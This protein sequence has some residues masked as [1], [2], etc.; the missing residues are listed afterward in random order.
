[1]APGGEQLVGRDAELGQMEAWLS[2]VAELPTG[3]VIEGDPGAGKTALFRATVQL[4]STQT[5]RVLE[6]IPAQPEAGLGHSGLMDLMGPIVDEVLPSLPPPQ[7]DALLVALLMRPVGGAP[8]NRLA[9]GAATRHALEQLASRGPVLVAID[10][11]QWL[12]TA[13][14]DALAFALRRLHAAP[15][16][17]LG[18]RRSGASGP[19]RVAVAL[20]RA[21]ELPLGPLSVG[22]IHAI[23]RDRLDLAL[24]RPRL[25]RLYGLSAG[26]PFY[27]IEIG[28]GLKEGKLQLGASDALPPSL[29]S[30]V[31]GRIAALPSAAVPVLA[32]AA[33]T[34]SPTSS[35]LAH[36]HGSR[37]A[38]TALRSAVAANVILPLEQDPEATIQFT[39][40]LLAAAVIAATSPRE[41]QALNGALATSVTDPVQR[42]RHLAASTNGPN[43]A[44]SAV[45][46]HAADLAANRGAPSIAADLATVA[47]EMTPGSDAA[48]TLRR[49]AAAAEYRF[50]AGDA[51]GAMAVLDTLIADADPGPAR[52]RLL[53][54]KARFSHFGDDVGEGVR[55][56]KEASAEA[57][58]DAGL[59]AWI[60]EGLAWGLLL[61]RSDLPAAVAHAESA[62]RLA[63]RAG[64]ASLH[65]EALA[66]LALA[67]L[68]TGQPALRQMRRAVSLEPATLGLRVLRHPSFALGYLLS[69]MDQFAEASAV[70]HDLMGRAT[71]QGDDSAIASIL[72]QL[73]L[74][75]AHTGNLP[76]A[77]ALATEAGELALE[78]GQLPMQAVALSR[79]AL[80]AA[81]RGSIHDTQMAANSALSLAC[82]EAFD[83]AHP[84]AAL[85]RGGEIAL[86]ALGLVAV[87]HERWK[88]AHLYLG[89]LADHMLNAGIREP[90]ELRFLLDDVEALVGLGRMTE[91][92]DRL[93]TLRTIADDTKRPSARAAAAIGQGLVAAAGG[94]PV[95]ALVPLAEAVA[96]AEG[97]P[98]P[99]LRGRAHLVLGR[100]E[101][102]ARRRAA[103]RDALEAARAQFKT[104]EADGWAAAA[105]REINRIGGRTRS[106][107]ELTET[108]MRV[109]R[110]VAAG[111]SNAETAAALF[112]TTKAV[113]ANVSRIYSK[114][115]LRSRIELTHWVMRRDAAKQ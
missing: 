71:R 53:S 95:A 84:A 113:E 33:L 80:V 87:A 47:R 52:A 37:V 111:M 77:L 1:M 36:L 98:M 112:V 23:L 45:L 104:L 4:A 109:A 9:V 6:A 93:A 64:D 12:D 68:E 83:P 41:R 65:A 99:L 15:I 57:G 39:H 20:R 60:E 72:A 70:F 2:T 73:S 46:E 97:L 19:D 51:T 29:D 14:S 3:V 16:A 108:E 26:N 30:L 27:A 96:L 100:V 75:E 25:L 66:A 115:G 76:D 85:A 82:G 63:V 114:L 61:M 67:R 10:D 62:T 42:A 86:V 28:R 44:V 59:R 74:I 13:T 55:L 89:P 90:G 92:G 22:A 103:A 17:F 69:C 102:R 79:V 40:P 34:S 94:D 101:R 106:P 48:A 54:M 43:L 78:A 32:S 91:A 105:E 11:L 50:E 110:L 56:L 21:R 31:G 38:T 81:M 49:G 7:R 58:T 88:E 107:D 8:P 24:D 5:Y 18:A 35:L